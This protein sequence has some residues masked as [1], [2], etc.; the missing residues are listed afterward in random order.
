M[1]MKFLFSLFVGTLLLVSP[2]EAGQEAATLFGRIREASFGVLV[3]GRLNGSGWFVAGHGL[4]VT[5]AHTV[6]QRNQIEILTADRGRLPARVIARDLRHDLCLLRV[7]PR[8]GFFTSLEL[9]NAPPASGAELFLTGSPLFRHDLMVPG[10]IARSD[11]QYEWNAPNQ[12]YTRAIPVAAV[13]APGFSGGPWTNGMGQVVGI[14]SGVMEQQGIP[15]GLA[16]ASPAAAVKNLLAEK[17]D[18]PAP[19][20]GTVLAEAWEPPL[21]KDKTRQSGLTVIQLTAD[22]SLARAGVKVGD[23]ILALNG[24]EVSYRDDFLSG[25]EAAGVGARVRL[26]VEDRAGETRMVEVEVGTCRIPLR[27]GRKG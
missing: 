21:P 22:S 4:A 19:T 27:S 26:L 15:M 17:R 20:V 7:E 2:A 6:G 9:V 5:T 24:R 13:V 10:R 8:E 23:S 25:I 16:F 3:D 12:C 14:Q 1:K 11:F 18:Q